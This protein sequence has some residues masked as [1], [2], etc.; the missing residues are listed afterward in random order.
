MLSPFAVF[1]LLNLG[2]HFVSF[3]FS[4]PGISGGDIIVAKMATPSTDPIL[5]RNSHLQHVL[6]GRR[7]LF[8]GDREHQRQLTKDG[9]ID[10]LCVLYDECGTHTKKDVAAADF[11]EKCKPS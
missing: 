2:T 10:A 3:L 5:V 11:V 6:M 4:I 9:L 7:N 1:S 8:D